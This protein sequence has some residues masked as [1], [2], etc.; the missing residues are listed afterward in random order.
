MPITQHYVS[1]MSRDGVIEYIVE[2]KNL[3]NLKSLM[4]EA[5][6]VVGLLNI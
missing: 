3:N 1:N 5:Q 4:W 2:N 6:L